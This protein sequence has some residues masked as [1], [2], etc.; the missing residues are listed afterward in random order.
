[1]YDIPPEVIRQVRA[2]QFYIV[3]PIA[4]LLDINDGS[5]RIMIYV[6]TTLQN[7]TL[8]D[9]WMSSEWDFFCTVSDKVLFQSIQNFTG[10]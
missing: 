1:M 4:E 2:L 10:T 8:L 9:M 7:F 6:L 5:Y 3:G